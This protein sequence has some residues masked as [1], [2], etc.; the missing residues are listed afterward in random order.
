[1]C[2]EPRR[3]RLVLLLAVAAALP[4]AAQA[5]P[6]GGATLT[7]EEAAALAFP[8]CTVKAEA[9][10]LTA[11]QQQAAKERAQVDAVPASGKRFVAIRD[12]KVVGHAYLD[13]RRIR[14]HAQ[15]LLVA[16][17]AEHKVSRVEI[18]AFDE[19]REYRPRPA[20]YAQFHGKARGD[21]LQPRKGIEPVAGAT[22]SVRAAVDAVRTV[23][24]IDEQLR[25]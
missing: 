2:S 8:G 1:M 3:P 6:A 19:P 13:R 15:L 22:L 12:G 11:A 16:L 9:V 4:L 17:D 7:A 20:F 23:L 10:T 14:T 5:P 24:A 25:R 21:P 18:L